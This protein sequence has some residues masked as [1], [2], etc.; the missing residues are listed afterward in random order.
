MASGYDLSASTGGVPQSIFEYRQGMEFGENLGW[1]N[2]GDLGWGESYS[3]LHYDLPFIM[4]RE[5]VRSGDARAFQLGSEMTRYRAD[6]GQYHADDYWDIN[7]EWNLKG[8]AF[9]EKGDHGTYKPPLPSHHWVEGLWLYWA[10]T[11]DEAV[12]Q[13]ALDGSDVL[14]KHPMDNYLYGLNYNE[15]RWVGWPAYNMMAACACLIP[16][17]TT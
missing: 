15:S 9:Y 12:H 10:L 3:N 6:W 13:S 17:D 8:M 5:Y 14:L 1:R 4:L 11:G 2:F 16:T 7:S